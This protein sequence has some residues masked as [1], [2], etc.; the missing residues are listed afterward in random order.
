VRHMEKL[1]KHYRAWEREIRNFLIPVFHRY[2]ICGTEHMIIVILI[3]EQ[4]VELG[5]QNREQ[6]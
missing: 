6:R 2:R 4:D 1:I 3:H 5:I